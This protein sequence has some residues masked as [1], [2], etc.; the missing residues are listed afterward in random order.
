V[1][2][3]RRL[4][5][6]E[7]REEITRG[8]AEGLSG[9]DIAVL[10]GRDASVVSRE[11]SRGGGRGFYRAVRSQ[12]AAVKRRLRPKLCKLD[13][14]TPLR[15]AVL[16][17]L[18]KRYSPDQIAGRLVL[19][20]PDDETMRIS[21]EAI[22]T[23]IYA[24]PVGQL[25]ALAVGLR[26]GRRRRKP[27]QGRVP[28]T[29][30][31]VAP[32]WIDE[33]PAD[34]EDRQVPGHWEGDLVIGKKGGSAASSLVERTSRYLILVPLAARDTATV[35]NAVAEHVIGLPDTLRQ[36][37]T[38]DCGSE[39]AAHAA[40][41]LAA[42][43]DVYF[44]HPHSPWERGTNEGTNRWIREY[45]PKGTVIPNDAERLAAIAESLNDRPRRILGYRKPKE[46][47]AELLL[48]GIASTS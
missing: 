35:T 30:N 37:L 29:P 17:L 40:L 1:G 12:R 20:Y 19:E 2:Q 4:V 16:G 8:I 10:I 22:Y 33:R 31:I 11:I 26:S 23:W 5:T 28:R 46:V 38:W 42:D 9:K 7:E 44:A 24:L 14:D 6:V 48:S 32:R 25:A 27:A 34:A 36:S 3:V 13:P 41:T 45:L 15:E 18:R 47:F 21:H 39:M 43:I